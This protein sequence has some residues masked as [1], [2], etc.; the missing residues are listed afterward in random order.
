MKFRRQKETQARKESG[1][2]LTVNG[3][4]PLMMT[5]TPSSPCDPSGG[6]LMAFPPAEELIEPTQLHPYAT[7]TSAN[8]NASKFSLNCNTN[9][10]TTLNSNSP[11]L[12]KSNAPS[13]PNST[14]IEI[15]RILKQDEAAEKD[16]T[17]PRQAMNSDES[18]FDWDEDINIDDNGQVHKRRKD[19]VR[20][21][22]RRLSPFLRM[23]IMMLVVAPFVALPAILT[24]IFLT[25]ASPSPEPGTDGYEA[26]VRRDTIVLIFT[27]LAFMWCIVCITN[28]GVD[29][30]PVVIVRLSSMVTSSRLEAVKSKLLIF[31]ATK[32]YIKWLFA[33]CWATGSFALLSTV[34]H[35]VIHD[36][37]W[38]PI[39]IKVLAAIIAGCALVFVEKVLLQIISK[40][41]HQTAYADRIKE[42]KY[43]LTVLDR[44]GTS[45]KINKK[46]R[47]THS[48]NNT[49]DNGD[50]ISPFST[51]YRSR[52]Q[53]RS[54]SLDNS[55]T[56]HLTETPLA[57]PT[58]QNNSR[59]STAPSVRKLQRDSKGGK[60]NDIF[61]GINRTLH[62]IAMADSTPAKDINSTDNAKRLA[63][64]LF[65]NLQGNGEELV[66]ED[67]YPY[68]QTE[69]DAKEA[70]AIF[71]KDGNGDISK[72]EMKEKIFYVY[73]ER[74][75]L[76]TS[77]RDLSQAVGKLDIIFL[78][79]VTVV[80]LLIILS[81]F[82]TSVVQ[83]MLSIGSFLVALSFVFGNSL[84]TLFENI[85]FLFITHPY[86]SGDLCNIDGTDMFVREVGLN[87]TMFVTWDGKRMYYPNNVLSQKPIHNVRRS[88]NMS[89]KI[90]LNVDC[91]T[92]QSKILELRARMRDFLVR[93]SK[94]FLPDME[95][96]IQ[97]MDVKL[98]ISMVI[99]HKGNWQDSGRR[100]ARRTKFNFALK[101]AVEEIGIKYYA[102]PQRVEVLQRDLLDLDSPDMADQETLGPNSPLRHYSPDQVARLYRRNTINR[103]QGE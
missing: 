64:T 92:P 78:T 72:R 66:V 99:E 12:P 43:A 35:P 65:Y 15:E 50:Y 49:S 10:N 88:P 101:D 11:H 82:G 24:R 2:H 90:V 97:E 20:S 77:L 5:F 85:V 8:Y 96:Q 23:V 95:I 1:N 91:Y 30:I 62:G 53:S 25:V 56:I 94:E 55:D 36:Q 22:W 73:K 9:T 57:T 84:K 31:V 34:I 98:K 89:E 47:P 29:I 13:L 93:E 79:I 71:D 68:F 103:P 3:D 63:K 44:L 32:K 33:A 102:L 45:K 70:F 28:W 76:H 18:D 39:M 60:P 67:F 27:W 74:K 100:W 42:N 54:H 40:N 58:E 59:N 37:K 7:P 87:S 26:Y 14:L 19:K 83:N 80:W 69:E 86:D 41:F 4:I 38:Q 81:I 21:K 46:L 52:Q 61:K 16:F 75:D 17:P 6:P 48:R 51:G